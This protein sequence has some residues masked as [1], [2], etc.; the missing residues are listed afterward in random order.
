MLHAS[1]KYCCTAQQIALSCGAE[2][3]DDG[4]NAMPETLVGELESLH[5]SSSHC[6]NVYPDV[7]ARTVIR[8]RHK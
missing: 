7:Y 4:L 1:L 2:L 6:Q 8:R 5:V 3:S